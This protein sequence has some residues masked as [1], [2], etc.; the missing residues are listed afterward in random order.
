MKTILYH[1]SSTGNSLFA[2]RA[3]AK[4][5]GETEIMPITARILNNTSINGAERI[6]IIFP[7][8]GW[9]IP[10]IVADF[11]GKLI[12]MKGKYFF[13]IIF[14]GHNPGN[15]FGELTGILN[16]NGV[17][18]NA[19]FYVT[20]YYFSNIRDEQGI[21]RLMRKICGIKPQSLQEKLPE[22]IEAVKYQK[23][24]IPEANTVLSRI[25]GGFFHKIAMKRYR[26]ADRDFYTGDNC[27]LCSACIKVCPGNNLSVVNGKI[28]WN[29]HCEGCLSCYQWCPE[30]AVRRADGMR[31]P[32]RRHH[33]GIILRDMISR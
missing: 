29:G 30:E 11:A 7:V 2:A 22:I 12:P 4:E 16:R 27:N 15:A 3:V 25:A 10:G 24:Q 8:Y 17:K 32:A 26:T 28:V 13:A 19:V 23:K 9:G 20:D 6:G 14:W 18:I 5:L 33:P 31:P 21:V 1:F